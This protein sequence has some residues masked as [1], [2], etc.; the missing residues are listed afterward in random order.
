MKGTVVTLLEFHGY[1]AD[2]AGVRYYFNEKCLQGRTELSM[3]A[4]GSEVEF[5]P[6]DTPFGKRAK[7]VFLKNK[8]PFEWEEGA[9][10]V[11]HTSKRLLRWRRG[12]PSRFELNHRSLVSMELVSEFFPLIDD[13]RAF[14]YEELYRAGANYIQDL[15]IETAVRLIH[16]HATAVFRYRAVVGVYVKAKKVRGLDQ[17]DYYNNL[18]KPL[19]DERLTQFLAYDAFGRQPAVAGLEKEVA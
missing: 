1:I 8:P 13:A 14:F 5:K 19:I 3:L 10:Y 11:E 4:R 6:V 15:Q 16:G 17:A 9:L 12:D 18:F 2:Q 7:H